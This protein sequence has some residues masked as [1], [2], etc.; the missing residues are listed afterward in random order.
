MKNLIWV[1]PVHFSV[2]ETLNGVLAKEL[3]EAV[4][5]LGFKWGNV[6]PRC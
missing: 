5:S 4:K 6:I 3:L 2:F 1:R